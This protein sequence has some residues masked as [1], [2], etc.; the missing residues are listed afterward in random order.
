MKKLFILLALTVMIA[1]CSVQDPL[2]MPGDESYTK[3]MELMEKKKYS[4]AA[5]YFQNT[6]REGDNTELIMK[7]NIQLG[8]AYFLDKEYASAIPVYQGYLDIY[9]DGPDEA[10]AMKNLALSYYNQLSSIDRNLGKMENALKYF[11]MLKNKYPEYADDVSPNEKVAEIRGML[12]ERELYVLRFY[13]RIKQPQ[14]AQAR[15][16]YLL[17]NYGDTKYAEPGYY[18]I[19]EYYMD[20]EMYKEAKDAFEKYLNIYPNGEFAKDAHEQLEEANEE[21]AKMP[22]EETPAEEKTEENK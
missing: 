19:G 9:P 6:I 12:A 2:R 1:A 5:E 11:M 4:D 18:D 22:V 20:K 10:L 15:A 7:G 17:L 3:G 21:I 14:C 16:D 8:N 13:V